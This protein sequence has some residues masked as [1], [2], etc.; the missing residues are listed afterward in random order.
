MGGL[1]IDEKR[2]STYHYRHLIHSYI[3]G[4][5]INHIHIITHIHPM[6]APA[7]VTKDIKEACH[8]LILRE[9]S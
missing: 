5:L 1:V 2:R 9:R 3:V 4:G 7:Y 6:L 8:A